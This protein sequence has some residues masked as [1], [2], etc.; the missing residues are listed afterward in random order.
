MQATKVRPKFGPKTASKATETAAV[1]QSE[2]AQSSNVAIEQATTQAQSTALAQTLI[3]SAISSLAYVRNL[4]PQRCFAD[5]PWSNDNANC[6]YEDFMAGS[7]D[8]N[9]KTDRGFTLKVMLQRENHNADTFLEWLEKGAFDAL[10]KK[11][12]HAI[13][14]TIFEDPNAPTEVIETYTFTINYITNDGDGPSLQNV[15][16]QGLHG[17]TVT[18]KNVRYAL[19]AFTR[20]LIALC[21]SLPDLPA[22]R[23]MKMR[24]HYT[25]N[26]DPEYEASGFSVCNDNTLFF[27]GSEGWE[28]VTDAIGPVATGHHTI[29]VKA[30]HLDADEAQEPEIPAG[31]P[32]T[33]PFSGDQD[34]ELA[35]HSMQAAND[36][37][38]EEWEAVKAKAMAK[39]SA[40]EAG[41]SLS[42]HASSSAANQLSGGDQRP[43]HPSERSAVLSQNSTTNHDERMKK[44]LS[45]WL[46]PTQR[47]RFMEETQVLDR[48]NPDPD[49][50]QAFSKRPALVFSQSKIDELDFQ[51]SLA[52]AGSTSTSQDEVK[53]SCN[54]NDEVEDRI[55]CHYCGTWQ[56]L[57]CYGYRGATDPR[58][59]ER[60]ICYIC[61]LQGKEAPLL[62]DL[63]ELAL[64]RRAI[65]LLEVHGLNN[66]T[67]FMKI[68]GRNL[69]TTN[70]LLRHLKGEKIL[71]ATPGSKRRGFPQTGQP[72]FSIARTGQAGS[73]LFQDYFDPTRKIA[74][75]VSKTHRFIWILLMFP[76]SL[77]FRQT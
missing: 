76:L 71:V 56:H 36:F 32:C 14:L 49:L 47:P 7:P 33:T 35:P 61:L 26:C 21:N 67:Q 66:E 18:V 43:D 68:L 64:L 3:H 12:L 57:H 27:A 24:L 29:S 48:S 15:S 41:P 6:S 4:F 37:L 40:R 63:Q 77:K 55:Q 75:H 16:F 38:K 62:A 19:A 2:V 30:S 73:K 39:L 42:R 45:A 50:S 9:K 1:V 11:Y 8:S 74:H 25:D 54:V 46:E 28:K 5:R 17:E 31:L 20:K 23:Y 60:H 72:K 44:G 52:Q 59:P 13:Q 51:R 22:R 65:R 70:N 69:Q 53:C 58:L 10:K 34:V